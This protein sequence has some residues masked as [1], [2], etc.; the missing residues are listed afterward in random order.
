V[1]YWKCSHC[2]SAAVNPGTAL[3]GVFNCEYAA[4]EWGRRVARDVCAELHG[5]FGPRL[6]GFEGADALAEYVLQVASGTGRNKNSMLQDV[7]A[8][9]PTEVDYLNGYV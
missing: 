6:L 7:E 2:P 5:I 4:S 3:L 8:G 1:C 9:R